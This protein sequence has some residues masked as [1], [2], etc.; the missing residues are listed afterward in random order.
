MSVAV[1]IAQPR[2]AP[3]SPWFI[4]VY[5][6]AGAATPA[7]AQTTGSTSWSR[8]D[9]CPEITSRLISSD[10]SRKNTAIRPSLI[11]QCSDL[12]QSAPPSGVSRNTS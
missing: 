10:T 8:L 4:A 9:S 2:I 11:H 12:P 6:S 5:S 7:T 3:A 1:G